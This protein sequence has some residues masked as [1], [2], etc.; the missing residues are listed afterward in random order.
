MTLEPALLFIF[1]HTLF[2]SIRIARGED[3]AIYL[4][5]GIILYHAFVRGTQNG[6]MCLR[7]NISIISS[8]NIRR[9]IFPVVATTTASFFLLVEVA[10][11]FGLMPVFSF[12]PPWT[13]VFLPIILGLLILLILGVSYLLSIISVYVRDI[14]PFWGI[15][16]TAIFFMS[17]VFWYIDSASGFAI[18]IQKFNPI[19]QLIELGHH[20][21]LYGEIP[22][23][24]E[25]LYTAALILG[26][27]FFGFAIFQKYQKG[28]LESI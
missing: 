21:I 11:L 12:I 10:V 6:M 19:G 4:L 2:T 16:S 7:E 9:E 25:W 27:L 18:E 1:L 14:Q 23:L 5:T 13:V 28:I 20:L 17:P 22:T 15:F 8:L 3:F 26:I 24:N